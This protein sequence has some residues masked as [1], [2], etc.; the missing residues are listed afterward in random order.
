MIFIFIYLF[1]HII[2]NNSV[3]NNSGNSLAVLKTSK[4]LDIQR[5]VSLPFAGSIDYKIQTYLQCNKDTFYNV[6][7]EYDIFTTT[8]FTSQQTEVIA[9]LKV[10][11]SHFS[12]QPQQGTSPKQDNIIY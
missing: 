2:S 6:I 3:Q 7:A 12:L 10:I 4:Y 8:L 9:K 5:R 1:I 11:F